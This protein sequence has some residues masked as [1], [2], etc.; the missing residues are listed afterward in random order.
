RT[1]GGQRVTARAE[2]S[3]HDA[4]VAGKPGE[5]KPVDLDADEHL[6]PGRPY[7][8]HVVEREQLFTL[9]CDRQRRERA[10]Y[11]VTTAEALER[12]AC[13]VGADRR[14]HAKAS[15]RDSQSG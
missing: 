4:P 6:S 7:D 5:Q 1:A 2:R 15:E 13:A 10:R 14:Q 9:S 11:P 12:R 8:C 3:A